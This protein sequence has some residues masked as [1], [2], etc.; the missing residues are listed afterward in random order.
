MLAHA[1][2]MSEHCDTTPSLVVLQKNRPLKIGSGHVGYPTLH[3]APTLYETRTDVG[4]G[5]TLITTNPPNYAH[6]PLLDH[7][8]LVITLSYFQPSLGLSS[9]YHSLNL[10]GFALANA[11]SCSDGKKIT[12]QERT[13]TGGP[14]YRLRAALGT[15]PSQRST[16]S[17]RDALLPATRHVWSSCLLLLSEQ[18]HVGLNL[19]E[20]Q[21]DKKTAPH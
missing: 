4:C 9:V 18:Q 8:S 21:H 13:E 7:S 17:H 5:V 15:H 2:K 11:S 16:R 3:D 14:W 1:A 19:E 20:Q 12:R 10:S 6:H